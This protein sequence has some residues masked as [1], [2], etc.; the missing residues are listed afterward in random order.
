MKVTMLED[1]EGCRKGDPVTFQDSAE[2]AALIAAGKA[3]LFVPRESQTITAADV[4]TVEAVL[5]S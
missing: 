5:G 4:A 1:H 3:E 2:A